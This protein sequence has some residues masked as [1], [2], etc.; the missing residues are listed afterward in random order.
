MSQAEEGE[1]Q[2]QADNSQPSNEYQFAALFM[3]VP[4]RHRQAVLDVLGCI[5]ASP[6]TGECKSTC[7]NTPSTGD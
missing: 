1:K 7:S 6:C 2:Q 3:A 4:K 5:A